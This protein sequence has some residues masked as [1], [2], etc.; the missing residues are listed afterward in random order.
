LLTSYLVKLLHSMIGCK[1]T[2]ST[3]SNADSGGKR[4]NTHSELFQL[5][6]QRC[7]WQNRSLKAQKLRMITKIGYCGCTTSY[8]NLSR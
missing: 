4:V 7:L 2:R 6:H 5:C 1:A 8:F 3:S